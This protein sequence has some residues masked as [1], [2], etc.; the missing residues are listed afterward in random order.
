MAVSVVAEVAFTWSRHTAGWKQSSGSQMTLM[1]SGDSLARCGD[2]SV[3]RGQPSRVD[4]LT[5]EWAG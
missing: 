3:P 4:P 5:L 2:L 1:P